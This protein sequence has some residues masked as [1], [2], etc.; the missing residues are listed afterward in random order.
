MS[1][2]ISKLKSYITSN[3]TAY[4]FAVTMAASPFL[5]ATP[6]EFLFPW[7]VGI[8]FAIVILYFLFLAID[9]LKLRKLAK[10]MEYT[11]VSLDW[12]INE[13]G[14]FDGQFQ[15]TLRNNSRLSIEIL[16]QERIMWFSKP[17]KGKFKLSLSPDNSLTRVIS[18]RNS[19]YRFLLSRITSKHTY[20]VSWDNY[21]I[22][23][24]LEKNKEIKYTVHINTPRT[25]RDAF[26]EEGTFA[27][28]SASIPI[29]NAKLS[30]SAP[31]SL[32]FNLL[33]PLLVVNDV[34]SRHPDEEAR[35]KIPTLHA[36]GSTIHWEIS[37]LRAGLRYWF[38]Y[39]L[40]KN[41]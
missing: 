6:L 33:V 3:L 22:D 14:D 25:E 30:Y 4:I 41:S 5:K 26:T 20:I 27:G 10:E 34:G 13:Q 7:V 36:N 8:S 11:E 1:V 23:P 21:A 2:L 38:K 16:P 18:G 37:N 24:P 19:I 9:S 12:R 29:R 32:R 15:Y 28:I 31:L 40:E 17:K 35:H 39:K